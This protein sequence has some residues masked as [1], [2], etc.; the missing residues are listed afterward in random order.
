MVLEGNADDSQVKVSCGG[1]KKKGKILCVN[2]F[3]TSRKIQQPQEKGHGKGT[4][5]FLKACARPWIYF[6]AHLTS[7]PH[8]CDSS[9]I[10][11]GYVHQPGEPQDQDSPYVKIN[12]FFLRA[13]N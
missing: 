11:R 2:Y 9:T 6:L 8:S 13:E 12:I 10:N 7:L 3:I 4:V 1:K 5:V